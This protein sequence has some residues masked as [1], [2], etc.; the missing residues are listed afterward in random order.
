MLI[1]VRLEDYPVERILSSPAVCCQK[2]VQPLAN[3][4]L[5]W[6]HARD[7]APLALDHRTF[8]S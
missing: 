8:A 3:D 5:L 4:R 1:V 7:L 6:V 2:T